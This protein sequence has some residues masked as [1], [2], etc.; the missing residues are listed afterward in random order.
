MERVSSSGSVNTWKESPA[1]GL[2]VLK[3]HMIKDSYAH[4]I[5]LVLESF[6]CSP[7]V[8]LPNISLPCF[9]EC[10]TWIVS[11][12]DKLWCKLGCLGSLVY[13]G[14]LSLICCISSIA[15]GAENRQ[16]IN[17]KTWKHNWGLDNDNLCWYMS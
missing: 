15:S 6:Y 4:F 9:L 1:V 8:C 2:C 14:Y 11:I 3:R 17:N 13:K 10:F 7:I 16:E 12:R 5:K